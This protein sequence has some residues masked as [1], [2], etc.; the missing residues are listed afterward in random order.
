MNQELGRALIIFGLV[1]VGV[2]VLITFAS[3][4]C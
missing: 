2:G 3:V 1:I 4:F